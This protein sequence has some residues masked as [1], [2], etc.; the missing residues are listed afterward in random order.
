MG[1]RFVQVSCGGWE[2]GVCY[3]VC[4]AARWA[5]G[6]DSRELLSVVLWGVFA[7]SID[8]PLWPSQHFVLVQR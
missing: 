7:V 5:S 8:E 1:A 4:L 2:V 6:W 3:V